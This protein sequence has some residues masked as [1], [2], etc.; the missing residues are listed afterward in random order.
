LSA[1]KEQGYM[2]EQIDLGCFFI[3]ICYNITALPCS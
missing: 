1:S 2:L 3:V